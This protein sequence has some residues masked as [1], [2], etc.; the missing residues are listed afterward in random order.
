MQFGHQREGG[1][2]SAPNDRHP[3]FPSVMLFDATQRSRGRADDAT[4]YPSA[5]PYWRS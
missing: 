1:A 4:S 2:A 5:R 3:R